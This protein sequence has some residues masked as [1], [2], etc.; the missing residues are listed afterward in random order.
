M[1]TDLRAEDRREERILISGG[2][3]TGL[4]LGLRLRQ[5]GFDPLVI[6]KNSKIIP[7]IKGEF[8][9]PQGVECLKQLGLFEPLLKKG[10][11]PI[12]SVS[13][14]YAHPLTGKR[15]RF[16]SPFSSAGP[17]GLSIVHE[18]ILEVFREQ[19]LKSGG[20]LLEGVFVK[21]LHVHSEYSDVT[22]SNGERIK[23]GLFAGA[24]GRSSATRKMAE[25]ETHVNPC[26]RVMLAGL[27]EGLSVTKDDFYTEETAD[28][29]LYAFWSNHGAVRV[30][31]CVSSDKLK[32]HHNEINAYAMRTIAQS[33]IKGGKSARLRGRFAP[34]F[35]GDTSVESNF[36][37]RAFWLGD[38][39]LTVDPLCGH[40]M[41]VA[42]NDVLRYADEIG[43]NQN[44]D[45]KSLCTRWSHDARHARFVGHW[46]SVLFSSG[47]SLNRWMKW[48]AIRKYE[49][50]PKLRQRLIEIFTGLNKD[51]VGLYEIPYLLGWLPTFLRNELE[52]LKL[53]QKVLPLQNDLLLSPQGLGKTLKQKFLA[54]IRT[55]LVGAN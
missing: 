49:N 23:A 6:E 27:V 14:G 1:Q 44:P 41:S 26:H 47:S 22:L 38:A 42:L 37:H 7:Q 10:A 13:H 30:Y 5:L 9:Q 2:G 43:K 20:R 24:E 54:G 48:N 21:E 33:A 35:V 55:S 16:R 25:L 50:D 8:F 51:R 46:I 52:V 12:R 53:N 18:D 31:L 45:F 40:G 34:M 17:L 4:A 15:R 29:V 32:E 39:A 11:L 28:G 3:V 36:K 19:Y